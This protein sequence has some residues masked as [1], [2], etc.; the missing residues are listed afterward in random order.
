MTG[1]FFKMLLESAQITDKMIHED[2]EE[3]I[4]KRKAVDSL[5]Q[6]TV[7]NTICRR[8]DRYENKTGITR[9][10]KLR[11]VPQSYYIALKVYQLT[12]KEQLVDAL[13]LKSLCISY[14]RLRSFLVHLANSIVYRWTKENL[15]FPVKGLKG[16]FVTGAGDNG[17]SNS[18]SYTCRED[19][20]GFVF[21]LV[22]HPTH[23][24][25]GVPLLPTRTCC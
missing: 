17:D 24:N 6:M 19:F 10:S 18:R 9:H 8:T 15:V 14:G 20:H 7:F 21:S 1:I 23:D 2:S 22:F 4:C 13:C 3:T 12:R 25:P 11:E 16:V 5:S